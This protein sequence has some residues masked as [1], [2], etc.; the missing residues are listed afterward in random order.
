MPNQKH[1]SHLPT[2]ARS[3]W[4]TLA[5]AVVRESVAT[6]NAD[7]MH[8]HTHTHTH[9]WI[10][11][12]EWTDQSYR[13]SP[14]REGGRNSSFARSYVTLW[15]G[16]MHTHAIFSSQKKY[17]KN[18]DSAGWRLWFLG[19]P[20]E[21]FK[22]FLPNSFWKLFFIQFYEYMYLVKLCMSW[23]MCICGP[24]MLFSTSNRFFFILTIQIL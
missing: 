4:H 12:T 19:I 24:N 15:K 14:E 13:D 3:S 17:N 16:V 11:R 20:N 21:K 8:L 2:S 9:V 10:E 1:W 23:S 7:E 22:R 5:S 18:T 6:T